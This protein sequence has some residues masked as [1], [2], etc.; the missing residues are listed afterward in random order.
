MSEDSITLKQ[1]KNMKHAI[2]YRRERVKRNKYI[3][4]RNYYTTNGNNQS[5]DELVG[6]ELANKRY[7]HNG[8]GDNPQVYFVSKKGIELLEQLL[9]CKIVEDKA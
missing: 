4:F 1:I 7:Y 5:W 2:G 6:L 3:M 8:C 9:E